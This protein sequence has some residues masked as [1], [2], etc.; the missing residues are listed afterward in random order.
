MRILEWLLKSVCSAAIYNPEVQSAPV[1]ILWPD[2]DRQWETVIPRLQDEMQELLV[3]GEY[4]SDKR[5]G[6]AIWLRCVI[7]GKSDDV[8]IPTD[9]LPVLYLPGVSRQDLRAVESCPDYIKPLAE[10]QYRGVI[11]SQVNAKDWTTLAFLKSADGGLGLDVSQDSNSRVSMQMALTQLLDENADLLNG[12]RLDKD[13]FNYL[14]TGGDPIRDILQWLDQGDSFRTGRGENGWKAFVEVS[15][16]RFAFNPESD[17][18]LA[19]AVKMAGHEGHWHPVWERFCEAPKR[20]PNIPSRI[21]KTS[22]PVDLF[23]DRTGWPQWN[24]AEETS[25]RNGLLSLNSMPAHE[26]RKRIQE[27][28]Q[29]HGLRRGLVWAELG[30][31]SLAIT[32]KYLVLLAGKTAVSLAAGTAEELADGYRNSGWLADDAV[33]LALACVERQ[34]DF[35]A[36]KTAIRAIYIPW[37]EESARYLQ[38]IAANEGYPGGTVLTGNARTYKEGECILFVDGL[39]FDMAK[40]LV[41]LMSERGYCVEEKYNWAALPSVTAT[42]K[43]SVTPVWKKI[44]GHE[45]DADF[46]PYVIETGQSLRGGYH[47][48]K[49]LT[50]AGWKI[51]EDSE[52]GDGQGNAWS[53]IGYI[54]YEGYSNGWKLARHIG[55]SLI[56]IRDRIIQLIAAGWE[57]VR[58]VTDHGWLLLPGGLPKSEMPG[59]LVDNKWGRCAVIKH[60]ASTK[61]RLFPWFWNPHQHFV[62]A[63][64]ISCFRKGEEYSHG[65]L[66]LQECL[67]LELSVTAGKFVAAEKRIDI[68][69][70]VWKGLRC[71]VAVEGEFS[72]LSLDVRTQPGNSSTSVVVSIKPFKDN[73][74]ASVVVENEDMEGAAAAIVLLNLDN[75]L[76]AQVSTVIGGGVE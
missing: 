49:L 27:M 41:K 12:K 70:I 52:N 57:N 42:G 40:R 43:P 23:S 10:L 19:G 67:T 61:E 25:L 59:I 29:Q 9:K 32:L 53:E 20:Y 68:T 4:N 56:G 71:T 46:E 24:E 45:A 37:V 63:D 74:T 11:W 14:L 47:L 55:D 15:K 31:A 33:I 6:P 5:T 50:D 21:R 69:D 2:G 28:E 7:A 76:V 62:L 65:G 39:R 30:E 73:G 51:L 13:Y 17:G 48:K 64:G 18:I 60:G 34:E 22:L 36:V 8:K 16:S 58:V 44:S 66:S 75:E 38:K 3:L 54:D 26:S 1:C 72:G 35:E